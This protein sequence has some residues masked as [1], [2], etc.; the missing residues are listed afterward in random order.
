MRGCCHLDM[1]SKGWMVNP[2]SSRMSTG[3]QKG[4]LDRWSP[5]TERHNPQSWDTSAP[6]YDQRAQTPTNSTPPTHPAR[7]HHPAST[8]E[9]AKLLPLVEGT[10]FLPLK[11]YHGHCL[12]PHTTTGLSQSYKCTNTQQRTTGRTAVSASVTTK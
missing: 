3:W 6:H 10:L 2:F 7:Y 11:T 5:G 1:M 4:R 9:V 8:I 12:G